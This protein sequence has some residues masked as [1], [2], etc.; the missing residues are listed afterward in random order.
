MKI[1]TVYLLIENKKILFFNK[2]KIKGI[3][4]KDAN[5][6]SILNS[7]YI[8]IENDKI[9]LE[10]LPEDYNNFEL[11][12]IETLEFLDNDCLKILEWLNFMFENKIKINKNK[13]IIKFFNILNISKSYY[14]ENIKSDK[15]LYNYFLIK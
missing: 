4:I 8:T 14:I 6:V 2:I 3:I 9:N 13:F 15:D 1:K 11:L 10:S 5:D 7:N 12:E